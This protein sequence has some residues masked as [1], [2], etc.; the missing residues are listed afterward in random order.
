MIS[1]LNENIQSFEQTRRFLEEHTPFHSWLKKAHL[2]PF[3]HDN[4]KDLIL[5]ALTHSSFTHE[6]PRWEEGNNERLEFL[7]DALLDAEI[8]YL[9]FE[10]F[11]HLKEGDLSKIRSSIVN[12]DVLAQWANDL[13][14]APFLFLGKGELQKEAVENAI[15][16]DAFEALIG[17]VGLIDSTAPKKLINSWIE[18]FDKARSSEEISLLSEERLNLFDPKTRLQELTLELFKELPEYSSEEIEGGFK[19]TLK[20]QNKILTSATGKSKKRA[21]ISAAKD[22]LMKKLIDKGVKAL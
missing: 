22:V 8:S 14:I 21:E 11:P 18:I 12:E 7:G 5:R 9:L 4:S 6:N 20:L 16:A 3:Y 2:E 1:L 15:L 13:G 19:V 10:K 17:A